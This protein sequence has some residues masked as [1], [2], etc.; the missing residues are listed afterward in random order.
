MV[1]ETAK[2]GPDYFPRISQYDT[3]LNFKNTCWTNYTF[4][5]SNSNK[6]FEG[7]TWVSKSGVDYLIGLVEGTGKMPMMKLQNNEWVKFVE[8]NLPIGLSFSDYADIA[9]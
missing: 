9:I 1:E 6:G 7:L 8:I 3:N 4:S 5:S 2:N